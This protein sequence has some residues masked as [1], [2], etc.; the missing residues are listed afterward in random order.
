MHYFSEEIDAHLTTLITRILACEYFERVEDVSVTLAP[1]MAYQLKGDKLSLPMCA[2]D[3][4]E[5]DEAGGFLFNGNVITNAAVNGS[6]RL[7]Q[8]SEPDPDLIAS[9]LRLFAYLALGDT[10][11]TYALIVELS[12]DTKNVLK[13]NRLQ[14][15]RQPLKDTR[16]VPCQL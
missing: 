1:L 2:S 6:Y 3:E 7:K 13:E 10:V 11:N 16:I 14:I 15:R 5:G 4:I 12:E 8:R 9:I